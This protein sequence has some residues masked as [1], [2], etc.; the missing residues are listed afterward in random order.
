MTSK[1]EL[2]RMTSRTRIFLLGFIM[3]IFI[4]IT[5]LGLSFMKPYVYT[6]V[7]L[8]LWP[9]LAFGIFL[10]FYDHKIKKLVEKL[11]EET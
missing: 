9:G 4:G 8:S 3:G 1:E 2:E 5:P 11:E 7:N 6:I 10:I